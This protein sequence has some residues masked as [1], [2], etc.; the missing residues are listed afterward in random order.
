MLWEVG[1]Q[2]HRQNK[3]MMGHTHRASEIS[4]DIVEDITFALETVAFQSVTVYGLSAA[5]GVSFHFSRVAAHIIDLQ[6]EV[7]S[8][9][10]LV[11]AVSAAAISALS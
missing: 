7:C 8:L 2:K 11:R 5:R 10:A 3:K 6:V 9:T 1:L 4:F